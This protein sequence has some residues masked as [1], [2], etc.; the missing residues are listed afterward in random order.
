MVAA[1][2]V[3]HDDKLPEWAAISGGHFIRI[4]PSYD[5]GDPEARV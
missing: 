1:S 4:Q 5:F 2:L 3:T